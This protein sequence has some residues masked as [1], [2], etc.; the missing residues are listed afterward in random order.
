MIRIN[1]FYF[2]I[3]FTLLLAVILTASLSL[4][5]PKPISSKLQ[6]EKFWADK[7]H[8][9]KKYDIIVAGDSR[10]YRG[11]DPVTLSSN[12]EGLEVLNFGF[13]SGGFNPLMFQEIEL[14]IKSKEKKRIIV[15]GLTPHSLT[16]SAQ[17]NSHF[18]QELERDKN[19]VFKR[20]YLNPIIDVF[21]PIEPIELFY[22]MDSG[23]GY[24]EDF[25]KHGWVASSRIPKNDTAALSSYQAV[26]NENQVQD[27]ILETL[28]NQIKSWTT[29]GMSVYAFR[30]PSTKKMEALED[31]ISGFNEEAIRQKII[32][33]NGHWIRIENPYDYISY[34]GS[35]LRYDSAVLFSKSLS[36][37]LISTLGLE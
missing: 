36:M 21:D 22:R 32:A 17:N 4:V 8:S 19:D 3:L 37:Y 10:V 15:L 1:Q 27:T 14:R 25:K 35:H 12:L 16:P 33:N 31:S 9:S 13:S 18:L 29:Q 28:Y 7:T 34:D 24:Y 20:R 11:I 2:R 5:R 23:P 30:M 26:F 6:K